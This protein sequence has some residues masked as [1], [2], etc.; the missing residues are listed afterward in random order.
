MAEAIGSLMEANVLFD[1]ASVALLCPDGQMADT[2]D[3][4]DLIEGKEKVSGTDYRN[5]GS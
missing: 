5:N 3:S 4:P 1:P 2:S